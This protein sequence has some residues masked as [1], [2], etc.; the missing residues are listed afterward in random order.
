MDITRVRLM[1]SY[2]SQKKKHLNWMFETDFAMTHQM[3]MT[4]GCHWFG[5]GYCIS[6]IP[7]MRVDTLVIGHSVTQCYYCVENKYCLYYIV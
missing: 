4:C 7:L 5:C 1:D 2:L 3:Q 6:G